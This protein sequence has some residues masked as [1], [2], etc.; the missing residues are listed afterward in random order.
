VVH[1]DLPHRPHICG[2][3][4]AALD[5]EP[6]GRLVSAHHVLELECGDI[7]LRVSAKK[8]CYFVVRCSCSHETASAPGTGACSHIDGRKRD[9]LLTERCLVGP[10]LATVIAAMAVIMR[11]SRCKIQQFLL[12]WPGLELG[13]VTINR[14]IHESGPAFEPIVE[15]LIA[16]VQSAEL[17]NVDET[18][19][20]QQSKLLWM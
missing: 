9:L 2:A 5:A 18:P 10:M 12:D 16:E 6:L 11:L 15:D 8:H 13:R 3:W 14:C 20:Y 19:W 4:H 17:A 7:A 1:E